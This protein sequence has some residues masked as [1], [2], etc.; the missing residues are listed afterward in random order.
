MLHAAIDGE[1]Y[2]LITAPPLLHDPLRAAETRHAPSD[3]LPA[4][5]VP[6]T[7]ESIKEGGLVIG[8]FLRPAVL[9]L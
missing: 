7:A 9:A 1:P 5:G 8:A 4:S 3:A 6:F 2:D